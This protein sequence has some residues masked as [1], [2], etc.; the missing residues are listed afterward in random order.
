MP[1]FIGS[2]SLTE[3]IGRSASFPAPT[4]WARLLATPTRQKSDFA[5]A[6]PTTIRKEKSDDD[7]QED[8]TIGAASQDCGGT[9]VTQSG[10]VARRVAAAGGD[11]RAGEQ[12]FP[13]CPGHRR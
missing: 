13:G 2:S 9:D 11:R 7:N 12:G 4:F 5:A 1:I 6:R 3:S 10:V 8:S